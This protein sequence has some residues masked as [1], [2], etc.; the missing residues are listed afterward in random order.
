MSNSK[1]HCFLDYAGALFFLL[2]P[3]LFGFVAVD[4]ARNTFF[5]VGGTW[6]LYSALSDYDFSLVR[7]FSGV[8]HLGLDVFIALLLLTSPQMFDYRDQIPVAV[9]QLHIFGG[10]GILAHAL[11]GWLSQRHAHPY[12]EEA[13]RGQRSRA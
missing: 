10:L 5:L 6:L 1:L 13:F 9:Y 12:G 8:V 2:A 4:P 7:L 11:F 3:F